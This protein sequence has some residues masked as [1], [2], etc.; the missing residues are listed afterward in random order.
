VCGVGK[1]RTCAGRRVEVAG[2]KAQERIYANRIIVDAC[3]EVP[4]GEVPFRRVASWIAA[5][6]RRT[7]RLRVGQKPKAANQ[8]RKQ[9]GPPKRTVNTICG[10]GWGFHT[11]AINN[12]VRLCE[13]KP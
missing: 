2:R 12:P 3:G 1:E 4:K 5:V 9:S 8:E 11:P 13:G 6:R 10:Q 7:E